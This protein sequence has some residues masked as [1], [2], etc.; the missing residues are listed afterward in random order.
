VFLEGPRRKILGIDI[1]GV[2]ADFVTSFCI[3]VEQVTGKVI[4]K[5]PHRWSWY[6]DE[7]VTEVEADKVWKEIAA[8]PHFWYGL[9]PY[10]GARQVVEALNH[11]DGVHDIYFMT[12]RPPGAKYWTE[13]WLQDLGFHNPTVLITARKGLA[14]QALGVEVFIDDKP[15]NALEVYRA[16]PPTARVYMLSQPWNAEIREAWADERR[17]GGVQVLEEVGEMLQ[18]E[19]IDLLRAQPRLIG[20]LDV[21]GVEGVI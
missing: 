17:E 9:G 2:L 15:E 6:L 12:T 14:C 1:D 20:G 3:K 21:R 13:Q 7:G 4:G 16:L 19:G 8:Y 18:R 5:V 11:V 10:P